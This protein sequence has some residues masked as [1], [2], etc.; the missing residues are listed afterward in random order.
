MKKIAILL[1]AVILVSSFAYSFEYYV[2]VKYSSLHLQSHESKKVTFK[3]TNPDGREV[4]IPFVYSPDEQRVIM[5][6]SAPDPYTPCDD[7]VLQTRE[8]CSAATMEDIEGVLLLYITETGSMHMLEI[9]N[10]DFDSYLNPSLRFDIK[11]LTAGRS[12]DECPLDENGHLMCGFDTTIKLNYDS[13]TQKFTF[14][15]QYYE[16]MAPINFIS[17][18]R[19]EIVFFN[20][21]R[22]IV[23]PLIAN[24]EDETIYM[25]YNNITNCRGRVLIEG[26]ECEGN[27]FSDY[28]GMQLLTYDSE[29]T[30]HILEILDMAKHKIKFKDI[31]YNK[32]YNATVDNHVVKI[33][34]LGKIN[35]ERYGGD[36]FNAVNLNLD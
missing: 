23:I 8:S 22:K 10:V 26:G 20:N 3:Y 27:K 12:Y 1:F 6:K 2:N 36:Q 5:A 24:P 7:K 32:Y 30:I 28:E 35:I 17:N 25:D 31:T 4:S 19:T 16:S 18:Y 9:S 15:E 11:D 29:G 34:G 14:Q 13:T 21:N 33:K